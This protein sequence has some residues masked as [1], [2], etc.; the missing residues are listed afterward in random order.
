[1]WY[2]LYVLPRV[3]TGEKIIPLQPTQVAQSYEMGTRCLGVQ[4]GHPTPEVT[5]TVDWPSRMGFG[6]L[7]DN[8]SP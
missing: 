7:A 5:N 1:M 2:S 6:R 8:L 3:V 4:L